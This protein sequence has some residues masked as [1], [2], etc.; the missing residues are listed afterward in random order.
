MGWD[1]L[2]SDQRTGQEFRDFLHGPVAQTLHS[3]AG[4]MGSIL[5]W[6]TRIPQVALRVAKRE[7]S[8]AGLR[9]LLAFPTDIR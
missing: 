2:S 7:F 8:M 6:G 9:K 1:H 3:N 4:G 5:G